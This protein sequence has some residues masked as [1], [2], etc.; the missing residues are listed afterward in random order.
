M[1][2]IENKTSNSKKGN[3]YYN[4][5]VD[6]IKNGEIITH[7]LKDGR[8]LYVLNYGNQRDNMAVIALATITHGKDDNNVLKRM[9]NIKMN[10]SLKEIENLKA[11]YS[12]EDFEMTPEGED[13]LSEYPKPFVANSILKTVEYDQREGKIDSIYTQEELYYAKIEAENYRNDQR[14]TQYLN[15]LSESNSKEY[16]KYKNGKECLNAIITIN[17]LRMP[18]TYEEATNIEEI[19][20]S[21][22]GFDQASIIRNMNYNLDANNEKLYKD[23]LSCKFLGEMRDK[24]KKLTDAKLEDN[25]EEIK[26]IRKE[27]LVSQNIQEYLLGEG[28]FPTSNEDNELLDVLEQKDINNHED[29]YLKSI[30]ILLVALD[31]MKTKFQLDNQEDI[32]SY[33]NIMKK[34]GVVYE[35]DPMEQPKDE[36]QVPKS[37]EMPKRPEGGFEPGD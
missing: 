16:K 32:K 31:P 1:D 9:R 24:V 19:L 25:S 28:E 3:Q 12:G 23:L 37:E 18:K 34:F 11:I 2:V 15:R 17:S 7:R 13:L 36:S 27:A 14:L 29:L 10:P 30:Q 21:I 4:I 35:L 20:N 26:N 8:T 6:D 5:T 33:C 22:K